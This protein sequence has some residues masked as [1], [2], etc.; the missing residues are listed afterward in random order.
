MMDELAE[1]DNL[2]RAM[3]AFFYTSKR[4]SDLIPCVF[5]A[6]KDFS[7]EKKAIRI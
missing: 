2:I 3:G 5:Q 7:F 4:M 6:W 1:Y